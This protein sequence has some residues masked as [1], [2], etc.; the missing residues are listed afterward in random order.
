MQP[1]PPRPR[2]LLVPGLLCDEAAWAGPMAALAVQ[3]E[4][5]VARHGDADS[6][7]EMARR[8]L[9]SMPPDPFAL[10]GHSMGGRVAL[11]IVRRAPGRVA[12]LA[13]LD[14]GHEPL[15]PGEAG[16]RERAGREALLQRAREQGM[17]AIA[18]EWA[19]GMVL[20]AHWP[21]PV[22]AD[23][24]AMVARHSVARFEAQV[25]ALLGRPDAREQL[26]DI[27]CPTVLLC[28]RHDRWS[29]LERHERMAAL[30][31]G[32]QL[33]VVEDAAHMTTMEQPQAVAAVLGR[34]LLA[35]AAA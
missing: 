10:A 33:A 35:P 15:A 19:Q 2:L 3:A 27:T 14:T 21:M 24:T 20:P 11:E 8:A 16:A 28:G 17:A 6:I 34:W 31:P 1:T 13:L 32:A 22:F 23:I 18:A 9:A 4:C 7:G 25:H 26:R 12:R 29:P 5:T 30:I